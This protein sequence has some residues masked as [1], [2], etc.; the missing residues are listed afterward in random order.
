MSQSNYHFTTLA[1]SLLPPTPHSWLC[2]PTEMIAAMDFRFWYC[3]SCQELVMRLRRLARRETLLIEP[4]NA[5]VKSTHC[6]ESLSLQ[7]LPEDLW[8]WGAWGYQLLAPQVQVRGQM[9]LVVLAAV[10]SAFT[11]LLF[12]AYTVV[13]TPND[14]LVDKLGLDIPPEPLITLEGIEPRQIHISWKLLEPT[15]SIQ[16]YHIELNGKH[17]GVTKKHETAAVIASLNP[18]TIYS[19]RV[20]SVSPGRFQTP[21][22]ILHIRTTKFDSASSQ[23]G[24]NDGPPQVQPLIPRVASVP[25]ISPPPASVREQNTTQVPGRRGTALRRASP[26]GLVDLA[27]DSKDMDDEPVEDLAELSQQFSEINAEIDAIN[28]QMEEEERDF[29]VARR[30]KEVQKTTYQQELKERDEITNDLRRQVHRAETS[31]RGLANERAKKEKLLKDMESSRQKRISDMAKWEEGVKTIDQEIEGITKQKEALRRRKEYEIRE[32]KEKTAEEQR[33]IIQTEEEI[34]ERRANIKELQEERKRNAIDEETDESREADRLD[35]ERDQRFQHTIAALSQQ[36][37]QT[38][39]EL[40]KWQQEHVLARQRLAMLDTARRSAAVTFAPSAPM[41][42]DIIRR[43]DRTIRRPRHASSHGSN[44]SSPRVA[45][46]PDP[47]NTIHQTVT[48]TSSPM[49]NRSLPFNTVNGMMTTFDNNHHDE[50]DEDESLLA[51]PMSPRADSLLPTDLL[52][53]DSADEMAPDEEDMPTKPTQTDSGFSPFPTFRPTSLRGTEQVSDDSPSPPRSN[54]SPRSFASPR[55]EFFPEVDPDGRSI[56][57]SHPPIPEDAPAEAPAHKRLTSMSNLFSFNRQRGK[58]SSDQLPALGSLKAESHSFPRKVEDF[59]ATMQPR[60]RLSYGG[61]WA[62]PGGNFLGKQGEDEEGQPSKPSFTRR[63]FPNILPGIGKGSASRSYDPFAPRNHSLDP[64]GR[65][66]SSSPRPGSTYS[67]DVGLPRSSVDDP[68][69]VWRAGARNSPLVP[70]WGSGISRSHSRRPSIGYN[71]TTNL[72]LHHTDEDAEFIEPPNRDNR[73]LQAPI[74]TRPMSSS[75]HINRPATPKLNP[76]AP[77]FNM[78]GFGK[79]KDRTKEKDKD[80]EKMK[81][82]DEYTISGSPPDSRKSKDTHSIAPTTS[83]MESRES[84]ERTPSGLSSVPGT[85]GSLDST[86]TTAS[87]PTFISKITRKASS[88]KFDSW[89]SKALFT[90][91]RKTGESTTPTGPGT[92]DVTEDEHLTGSTEYLGRSTESNGSTPAATPTAE[93]GKKANR[94]SLGSWN[95]MRK[96]QRNATP[97]REDLTASEISEDRRWEGASESGHTTDDNDRFSHVSSYGDEGEYVGQ[98]GRPDS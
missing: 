37:N 6:M 25:T 41:D 75:Q 58:T 61:N 91:S 60:R 13:N 35:L 56:K 92:G 19:V 28:V 66:G 21:S 33:E 90:S 10:L 39:Q 54:S 11:W 85:I 14:V 38:W 44:V 24:S 42:M 40:Q 98:G 36:Y 48:T 59:D 22:T 77:A 87:K 30:E 45:Y 82:R 72:S 74:G 69:R 34:E 7:P 94:S 93:D 81:A 12:R 71:S 3:R 15:T 9:A 43:G 29:E 70:D 73:P 88:N 84:L 1:L 51:V 89:K 80:K 53:D 83:T 16:E 63:A 65:G 52:G 97:G 27:Q 62:F 4:Y 95:F 17:V 2:K 79:S 76:N 31:C 49:A 46:A 68:Y 26:T 5:T 57:S 96:K 50:D 78:F 86:P 32:V 23:D 8:T 20:F 47:L 67:F 64:G 55:E 18:T